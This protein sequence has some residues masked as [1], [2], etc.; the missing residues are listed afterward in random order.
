MSFE[1]EIPFLISIPQEHLDEL[2]AKLDL[3]RFPDELASAG[4][5]YGVPLEDMRRLVARW[6]HGFDWRAAEAQLNTELPQFTK[7]IA[8]EGHGVLNIHYVHQRS[9]IKEAIPL[10]FVHG[11]E[12]PVLSPFDITQRPIQGLV[13]S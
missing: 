12:Y 11:C 8:A 6:K 7:T 5:N 1:P 9:E 13:V 2:R 10:L 3:S 4:W